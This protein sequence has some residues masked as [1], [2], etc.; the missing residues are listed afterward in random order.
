MF[1]I[2]LDD[3]FNT[4]TVIIHVG[5]SSFFGWLYHFI[6]LNIY[7]VLYKITQGR[8]PPSFLSPKLSYKWNRYLEAFQFGAGLDYELTPPSSNQ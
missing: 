1:G 4:P 2:L 5:A 8:K 6:A 3:P 7:T